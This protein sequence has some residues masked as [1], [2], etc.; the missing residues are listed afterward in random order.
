M[1]R[2]RAIAQTVAT[3]GGID[4]LVNNASALY[5]ARTAEI[6]MKRFDLLMDVNV[7]GTFGLTRACLPYLR[8]GLNSH[9]VM[10]SPPLTLEPAWFG[11]HCAYSIT[12]YGM[13][14]CVLGMAEEFKA[15]G[16]AVNAIWPRTFIESAATAS[17]GI[18]SDACG[19]PQIVADAV[20]ALMRRD[21][22]ACT[23]HHFLDEE[24]L[25]QDGE[26]D[27]ARYHNDSGRAPVKDLFV[28]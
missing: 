12:K 18:S 23:G 9:V 28:R 14:L 13:S 4:I 24:I 1:T 26:R 25:I 8:Q 22:R 27:L 2:S 10:L 19:K 11:D 6:S 7:R 5:L 15:Y 20:C 16:I 21:S 3:F 17:V